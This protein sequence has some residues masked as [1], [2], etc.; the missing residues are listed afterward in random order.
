M[1]Y[2]V[3]TPGFLPGNSKYLVKYNRSIINIY[4]ADA[5][6]DPKDFAM[7][8]SRAYGELFVDYYIGLSGTD[9]DNRI[10]SYNVC[11]TKLLRA[12]EE[13]SIYVQTRKSDST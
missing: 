10:T 11:Y 3:I 8:L 1:L 6:S 7:E 12:K 13:R 5:F 9:A 2:E 4:G